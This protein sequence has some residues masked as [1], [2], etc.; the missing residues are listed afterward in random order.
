MTQHKMM[1]P[2]GSRAG[3]DLVVGTVVY[4]V[5]LRLLFMI[6]WAVF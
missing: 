1:R 5:V 4:G 2:R 6:C 3:S